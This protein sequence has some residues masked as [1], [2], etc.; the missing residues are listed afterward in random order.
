MRCKSFGILASIWVLAIVSVLS[1]CDE[2]VNPV[3]GTEEAFTFYGYFNPRSDTQA[4]RIYSIDGIL[5]PEGTDK[6]DAV[7]TSTNLETG[8]E[9]IWRDSTLYFNDGSVGH[10]FYSRF[11][12]LHNTMYRFQATNSKGKKAHVNIKTPADGVA[13]VSKIV[14]A[15]SNVIVELEWSSI[16]KVLQTSATYTVRVPFPD[17]SD[18]T[19]IRIPIPSG[20]AQSLGDGRWKVTILPSKDIGTIFSVLSLR[21]GSYPV[22]LDEI[23]VSA[24]VVSED[25]ESPTGTFDPELLVQPGIFSNVESGFGFVG[26]AYFDSFVFELTDT[27]KEFA[28]FDAK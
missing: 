17:R 10:V 14:A 26:G 13:Q 20:Q 19:T 15:R 27:Q 25:W 23:T 11:R 12:P 5:Q 9:Q 4:V 8:E 22:I 1:G 3:L 6:L 7:V 2:S 16:P 18:T 21:P 28:G 24:F